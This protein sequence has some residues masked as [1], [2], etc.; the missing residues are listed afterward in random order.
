MLTFLFIY[1]LFT[2]LIIEKEWENFCS[3]K[4]IYDKYIIHGRLCWYFVG[5]VFLVEFPQQHLAILA[6][7]SENIGDYPDK[8]IWYRILLQ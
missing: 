3:P 8:H 7:F 1:L 4:N 2:Y 6:L 5:Y